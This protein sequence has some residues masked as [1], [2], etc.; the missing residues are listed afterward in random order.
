M[1]PAFRN[2]TSFL[3]ILLGLVPVLTIL[4]FSVRQ[5]AIRHQM[6]EKLEREQLHSIVLADAEIQWAKTGKEIW[7]DGKMFDIKSIA[8]KG[9]STIFKGLFDLEETVLKQNFSTNWKKNQNTHNQL[10]GQFFQN[11]QGIYFDWGDTN[12]FAINNPN[13]NF[14]SFSSRLLFNIL[15]IP[16]PP[17]LS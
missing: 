12:S 15:E 11:L 5:Q 4:V 10:F 2:I 6:I 9:D 1:K 14:P 13:N 7:V 17:P 16:T 3:F 8:H